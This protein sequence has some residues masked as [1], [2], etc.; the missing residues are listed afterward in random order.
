MIT[1]K[2]AER[3]LRLGWLSKLHYEICKGVF[4]AIAFVS[5]AL[6]LFWGVAACQ[7][8]YDFSDLT[9]RHD[10]RVFLD[11]IRSEPFVIGA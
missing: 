4:Y 9:V 2:V 7:G 5:V 11:C 1:G 8:L 6:F 10:F 3:G